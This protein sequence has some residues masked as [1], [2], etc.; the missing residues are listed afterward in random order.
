MRVPSSSLPSLPHVGER[1]SSVIRE[2]P[3]VPDFLHRLGTLPRPVRL[4]SRASTHLLPLWRRRTP[5][6]LS[7]IEGH[8]PMLA[9]VGREGGWGQMGASTREVQTVS[10]PELTHT[11]THTR[12]V[13][14]EL[15]RGREA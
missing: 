5:H 7:E 11:H 10:L 3:Q 4:H 12:E 13:E 8:G 14:N 2:L 9:E 15:V 1:K 6:V